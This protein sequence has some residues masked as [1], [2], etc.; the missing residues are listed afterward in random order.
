MDDWVPDHGE[1]FSRSAVPTGFAPVAHLSLNESQADIGDTG[2]GLSSEDLAEA[3]AI[4]RLGVWRWRVG[5]SEF[6]WSAELFRIAARDPG[7][8][9]PSLEGTLAC[10][11]E[12]DRDL[13][14]ARLLAAVDSFD[15]EGREFRIVRPDGSERHCWALAANAMDRRRSGE[16]A[17]HQRPLD[18]A[19][20]CTNRN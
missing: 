5:T 3:F 17:D 16:P 20:T 19:R 4:A 10:I 15:P 6:L 2:L 1:R 11:H 8:F 7:S 18:S 9:A 14:R 13:I 12:D